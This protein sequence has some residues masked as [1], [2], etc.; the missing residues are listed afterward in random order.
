MNTHLLYTAIIYLVA[1]AIGYTLESVLLRAYYQK[2]GN[3]YKEHHFTYSKYVLFMI[4]P[5]IAFLFQLNT[6]GS[7]L[8]K[9]FIG[10]MFIGTFLEW[11]LGFAFYKIIGVKLWTYHVF[12]LGEY[13]SYLSIGFWG[14]AGVFFVLM[15]KAFAM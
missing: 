4:I 14:F 3:H 8:I 13:T 2:T 1:A 7:S 15:A 6:F 5:F 10:S 12:P 11:A 9:V